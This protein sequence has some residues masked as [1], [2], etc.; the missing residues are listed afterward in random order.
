MTEIEEG[1]IKNISTYDDNKA[2]V[3]RSDSFSVEICGFQCIDL[4]GPN[5]SLMIS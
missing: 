3:S 1:I 2:A 4:Q 5:N